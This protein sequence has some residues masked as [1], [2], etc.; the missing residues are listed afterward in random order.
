VGRLGLGAQ[1]LGWRGLI[2]IVLHHPGEKWM[3][4]SQEILSESPSFA[5]PPFARA[6]G[7]Q[8]A[9]GLS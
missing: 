5:F 6:I 1:L 3:T 9:R 4:F 8:F 2:R 7:P